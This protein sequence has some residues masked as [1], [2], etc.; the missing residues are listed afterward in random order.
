MCDNEP[1]VIDWYGECDLLPSEI[2]EILDDVN[3]RSSD[4]SENEE[5][6]SDSEDKFLDSDNDISVVDDA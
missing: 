6:F 4:Y 3:D 2:I 5:W 1:L